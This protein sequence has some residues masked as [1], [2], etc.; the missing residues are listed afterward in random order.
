[1]RHTRLLSIIE[2][3]V[4]SGPHNHDLRLYRA[5]AER[6]VTTTVLLPEAPGDAK[7]RLRAAGLPV[8]TYRKRPAAATKSETLVHVR[9]LLDAR[10]NV[11]NLRKIIREQA[12]DLVQLAD[13][14]H[15]HAAIAAKLER[16]PLVVHLVGMGG[17]LAA[18]LMGG[19]LT[20]RLADVIM[21]T[22]DH[23]RTA[24]PGLPRRRKH[25]VSYFPPVDIDVFRP[26]SAR[27]SAARAECG[28]NAD[29]IAIGYIGRLH[30]EKDHPTCVRALA[31]IRE[32]WPRARLI[33][34]GSV[35]QGC[36]DYM[37]SIWSLA[38]ALGL[39]PGEDVIHKDAGTRVADLAQAFDICWSMGYQEGAT[40][41]VGEAMAMGIPVVG[42]GNS[43]VREMI[44]EGVSGFL[45]GVGQSKELARVTSLLIERKALRLRMGRAA[46][47]RAMKLF[48]TEISAAKHLAAYDVALSAVGA[49][50]RESIPAENRVR[51]GD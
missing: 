12:I 36:S 26:D 29:D 21:T 25:M 10:K 19:I 40:S 48:S 24:F 47:A 11:R 38:E 7:L 34:M 18:R 4:F 50:G 22:G 3:A 5:L 8:M 17:T 13:P 51:A 49:C 2:Y 9:Y 32:R 15:P 37:I 45:V 35:D 27:R 46:R 20:C 42:A 31:L 33:M 16:R 28:L 30:P 23:T 44:E 39:R 14:F 43:A 41:S 6:G 1:V